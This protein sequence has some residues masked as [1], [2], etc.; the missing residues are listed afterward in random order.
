MPHEYILP[1]TLLTLIDLNRTSVFITGKSA[2]PIILGGVGLF[3]RFDETSAKILFF[4]ASIS[5]SY[6][7]ANFDVELTKSTQTR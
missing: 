4:Q 5:D 3:S 2:N 7:L 1:H 6:L